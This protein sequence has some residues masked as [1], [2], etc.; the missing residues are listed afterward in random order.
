MKSI[1]CP[2]EVNTLL[3]G[4]KINQIERESI[5]TFNM[6]SKTSQKAVCFPEKEDILTIELRAIGDESHNSNQHRY[7]ILYSCL[8]EK[9][10][11]AN[12]RH[13]IG[14]DYQRYLL[15]RCEID[16]EEEK[17]NIMCTNNVTRTTYIDTNLGDSKLTTKETKIG[18]D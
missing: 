3:L 6:D 13:G 1:K 8:T 5:D 9:E 16:A 4:A 15:K 7:P 10:Y 2:K 17:E 14:C 11:I 18:R 12:I